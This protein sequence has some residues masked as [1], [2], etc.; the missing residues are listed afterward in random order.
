MAAVYV[1]QEE[2]LKRVMNNKKLYVKLL[3]KFKNETNLTELLHFIEEKNYEKAE[4]CAH[5]LKGLSG[6]LSLAALY[7][8]A[9]ALDAQLKDHVIDAG[10]VAGITACFNET[11][12]AID[13]ILA[14]HG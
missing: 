13:E 12:K 11:Q 7:E 8:K 14:A 9:T 6:N 5:T 2:G 10:T 1:N 3:T 4:T